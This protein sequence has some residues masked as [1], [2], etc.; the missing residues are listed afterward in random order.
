[1]PLGG[2][3]PHGACPSVMADFA[4]RPYYH[5]AHIS[6]ANIQKQKYLAAFSGTV[7]AEQID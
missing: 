1:M 2:H 7:Q 4:R 6:S 3:L 5:I